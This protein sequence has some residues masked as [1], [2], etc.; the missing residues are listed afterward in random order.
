MSENVQ[1]SRRDNVATVTVDRPEKRNAMNV[2]TRRQLRNAVERVIDDQDSRVLVF[3]GAGSDSFIAGGDLD[4]M[5]EYDSIE[6]LEYL[7]KHA[8]G[9]Y[10]YI[11]RVPLP[12]VA[13]IDGSAF[14]GGLELALACDF[15]VAASSARLGLSE[16]G[17]GLLPGGGGTQRLARIAGTGVAKDLILTGRAVNADEAARLGVVTRTY[18]EGEFEA[19]LRSLTDRLSQQAPI[20]QRLAKQAID[21]T[22]NKAGFDVERF[23][24]ALLFGTDDFEEGI[25]AF[26]RDERSNF[27]GR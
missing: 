11:A 16:V 1:L 15:R 25:S 22:E 26:R 23:A 7:T 19:N 27:E 18:D 9:L 24:G 13:A 21:S 20:A 17:L 14:G 8:Q 3:R 6:G 4:V 5:A 10:N 12:T 2:Q